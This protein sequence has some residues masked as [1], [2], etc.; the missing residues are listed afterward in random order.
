MKNRVRSLT[1]SPCD[2]EAGSAMAAKF[3]RPVRE[4]GYPLIVLVL[5]LSHWALA[6][7]IM[8]PQDQPTIQNAINVATNGDTVLVSPGT[9]QEN[10]NFLGKA[11][12][13]VSAKGP[14]V[15]TIDGGQKDSVVTFNSGETTTSVIQG[16]TIQNGMAS[17][18]EAI[19]GGIV[20]LGYSSPTI[21]NNI[22]S[23]N[24]A[25][26][27][28]YGIGV[29]VYGSP[30]IQN[31][32]ISNNFVHT[33]CSGGTG[34]AGIGISTSPDS[35]LQII[36]NTIFSNSG[37]FEGG[38]ISVNNGGG[39]IANNVIYGNASQGNG[40][41]ISL[42]NQTYGIVIVQNLIYGNTA[43][44]GNGVY[45]SNPPAVLADNT[46]TDSAQ[47]NGGGTIW[48]DS[49]VYFPPIVNNII[50][51][52]GAKYAFWCTSGNFPVNTV[53]FNDV[54]STNGTPYGGM[55]TDQTGMNGNISADP[56]FVTNGFQLQ[57]NSPAIDAGDNSAANLPSADIA[58]SPRIV[59][60]RGGSSAVVDMGAYEFVPS[61][62]QFV[63]VVPCRVVDT[64]RPD[65]PFGDPPSPGE[66]RETF[67]FPAILIVVSQ[68]PP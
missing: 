26:S 52:S 31:N 24:Q 29:H 28:G 13:V 68:Q 57:T 9:Y 48:I 51:A 6:S 1:L 63:P 30:V 5:T 41:G 8:V 35:K 66:P 18:I 32:I 34:G 55:C 40:G 64:R 44:M 15:T 21:A 59:N 27:S 7:T 37:A 65:G 36:G 49:I 10:I 67:R 16:F 22:V 2:E 54:F 38:G 47:S 14:A 20:V 12:T 25:C 45:W 39:V 3:S 46:I 23:N 60:G 53:G 61:P 43:P 11:I 50:T 19:G 17:N 62:L 4:V 42:V 56:K 58:N 33:G